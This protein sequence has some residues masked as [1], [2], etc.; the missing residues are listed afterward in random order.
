MT[1]TNATFA[2][3]GTLRG[4]PSI[5][6]GLADSN[7]ALNFVRL[8]LACAVIVAH[9]WPVGGFGTAP[10]FAGMDSGDWAVAG[11][12]SLSGFLITGSRLR[13]PFGGYLLRR[14]LRIF[15]GFWACLAVVAFGF[16]PLSVALGAP[17]SWSVG[18]GIRHVAVNFTLQVREFNVGSTIRNNPY[19][20]AW[21]GSLWSLFFEFSAYLVVGGLLGIALFRRR[22]APC[23]AALLVMTTVAYYL[24]ASEHI[25]SGY[26]VNGLSLGTSFLAGVLLFAIKDRLPLSRALFALSAVALAVIGFGGLPKLLTAIPFAYGLL[27][28]GATLPT[29]IGTRN[30]V[31]YGVYVYA[32]PVQ[33][34]LAARHLQHEGK[35]VFMVVAFVLTL[36]LAWLSWLLVERPGM[37]LRRKLSREKSRPAAAM[38]APLIPDDEAADRMHLP[39]AT[40]QQT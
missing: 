23:F 6:Q 19:P 5:G 37:S 30:D 31:S 10:R 13:L 29:R 14:A 11:F 39:D 36:P 9:T 25:T 17:G 12:F 4:R 15:P 1:T 28:L 16:A 35:L 33:Q 22:T 24:A 32:F 20:L 26:V 34:C 21:N 27:Y 18:A 38:A 40:P 3:A 8:V 7:N 2:P